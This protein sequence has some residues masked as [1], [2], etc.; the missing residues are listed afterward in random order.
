MCGGSLGLMPPRP[1]AGD[2]APSPALAWTVRS[3]L[4]RADSDGQRRW[5][6]PKRRPAEFIPLLCGVWAG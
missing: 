2:A 5:R 1:D 3:R 6:W 4:G